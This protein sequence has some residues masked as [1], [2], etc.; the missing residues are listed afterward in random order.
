MEHQFHYN[1][2]FYQ[3]KKTGYWIST[4]KPRIRAHVWVWKYHNGQIEKGFHIH[5]IDENKSNNSI[6]NLKKISAFNHI[7]FHM[8]KE[9]NR[10]RSKDHAEKIRPLTKAWHKS[11][12]GRKWHKE[13]ALRC[14]F[15]NGK[16]FDYECQECNRNYKSKIKAENRSK[17][18][19]N[20]CKSKWRRKMRL[21]NVSKICPICCKNYESS[22]Y[23]R[24]KTCGRK[25]GHLLKSKID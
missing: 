5:H 17:F 7:S 3:D 4:T 15:G 13:H 20:A 10:K 6:E 14:N 24:S 22:K 1:K 9:E 12:E 11:E 23:S 19:S 25:C 21:D 2:K 16:Y 18:C 8:L